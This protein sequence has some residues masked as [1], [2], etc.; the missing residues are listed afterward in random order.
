MHTPL[1]ILGKLRGQRL[2]ATN[3]TGLH[4]SRLFYVTDRT[5]GLRFLVDTGAQVSVIPPSAH[6][7]TQLPSTLTLQ[8]VNNS[9]IRTYGTRSLTLNI[10]HRRNLGC[11]FVIADVTT[12]ILGADFLQH[13]S[14]IV[15]IRH[16][17]LLD[18]T[19]NITVQGITSSSSQ[20]SP[21]PS[22]LP[23]SPASSFEAILSEFPAVT[24]QNTMAHTVK[25]NVTHHIKTTGPPVSARTRRLAPERLHIASQEFDHMLELGI[26]RPSSSSWASPLH[27]VPKKTPGDWRPCGDYRALNHVTV[28]DRYP[29]PHIQDFATSFHGTRIFSKI[30]LIRAYHQIPV[31]PDDIP[32]TAITTPFGLFEFLRMLRNAAQTFQRFIDQVL[33]GLPFCYAYIDDLLVASTSPEQHQDHLRQVLQRLC[34][35]GIVINPAKCNLGDTALDFGL[36]HRAFDHWKTRLQLSVISPCL[37]LFVS[38]VSSWDSSISTT[39]SFPTV[40]PF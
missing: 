29:I 10:G 32:I 12:A 20:A 34:N 17:R 23:R 31:Q 27:M 38:S 6:E 3:V 37:H 5:S 25:H 30:D 39:I 40:L 24:Q 15:D 36:M 28:P 33:H 4:P 8:A 13:H 9:T 2:K 19:T 11:V 35:H 7:R 14:L 16:Q 26:I 22:L 21:S 18:T 1:F